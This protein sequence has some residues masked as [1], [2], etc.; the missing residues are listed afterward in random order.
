MLRR[1]PA[2]GVGAITRNFP[3]LLA[4]RSIAPALALGNAVIQPIFK[5]AVTEVALLA[6]L[7]R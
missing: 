6:D 2:V 5:S 3:L 4:I 7:F 1:L